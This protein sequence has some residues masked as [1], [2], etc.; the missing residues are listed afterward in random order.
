MSS[1]QK[2]MLQKGFLSV[3]RLNI[4]FKTNMSIQ[5]IFVCNVKLFIFVYNK[6]LLK[7]NLFNN[8]K[9]EPNHWTVLWPFGWT[10]VKSVKYFYSMLWIEDVLKHLAKTFKIMSHLD[11]VRLLSNNE[12][13]LNL[14]KLFRNH[15]SDLTE[16][17]MV[18]IF[19]QFH[20]T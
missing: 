20:V 2:K 10:L 18:C 12:I 6:V 14:Q 4:R 5:F 16:Q 9:L 3:G 13:T 8:F 15:F 17:F 1:N 7:L 19:R 11:W